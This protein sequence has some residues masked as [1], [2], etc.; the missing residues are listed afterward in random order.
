M[1]YTG[2]NMENVKSKN[3]ASILKLLNTSGPMSRKDIAL[4]LGL[5]PATLT[6]LCAELLGEG[7]LVEKGEIPQG[8]RAG[9]RK[10]LLDI[11]YEYRYVLTISIELPMTSVS[12][13]D[14]RGEHCTIKQMATDCD[15][16]AEEFLARVA[17]TSKVL[18]WEAGIRREQLLGVG[19]S[20]PGPVSREEGVS[21]RAYRIWDE[22]VRVKTCL[23]EYLSCPILLE[24][25]VRAFAQA[26][27]THGIGKR[28]KNL[29]FLKWG[30]G[31]GSA[32]IANGEIYESQAFKN[33]EI[34]HV[35]VEENGALCRCGRR[36]CLET[37]VST[38]PLVA[39]M[40][41]LCSPETTPQLW[42]IVE[43]DPRR[44]TVHTLDRALQAEDPALWDM[45][46]GEI[47]LLA[48][49][50]GSILTMLVPDH[51]I[52]Y[53][54]MFKLP[55]LLDHFIAACERYDPYYNEQYIIL[56][57][58]SEKIA[59]IGPLAVV[60]SELFYQ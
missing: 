17:D 60:V 48:N 29:V 4:Q 8:N 46:D 42:D 34:G 44:I 40:Q 28:Q 30:P 38:H 37:R 23:A 57:E 33:A 35:R 41:E 39:R 32:I 13:C 20:V 22:P 56:S 26:E 1:A 5:T 45:L 52:V 53:G 31:V 55:H 3:L 7:I 49:V 6:M 43:G 19:V 58:L 47:G 15:I 51:L 9:R 2:I 10:I 27:L 36:G 21:H 16:P 18:M 11:N 54:D 50:T 24:N 25:N 12:V 14:L 59:Y